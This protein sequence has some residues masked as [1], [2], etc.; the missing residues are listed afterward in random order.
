MNSLNHHVDAHVVLT[1]NCWHEF[2][3]GTEQGLHSSISS[4]PHVLTFHG[5]SYQAAALLWIPCPSWLFTHILRGSHA[6]VHEGTTSGLLAS[7]H[8]KKLWLS[9]FSS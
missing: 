3:T 4:D 5:Q 2:S 7:V 9:F 6:I 8:V 1:Q